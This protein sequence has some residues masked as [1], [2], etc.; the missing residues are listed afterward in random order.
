MSGFALTPQATMICPHGGTVVGIP[1]SVPTAGST[2]IFV[3]TDSFIIAGCPFTLP[4]PA[5]SPCVRVQWAV[6]DARS[7]INGI[8]TLSQTSVGMC[9][10]AAGVPQ[11]TVNVLATQT[12]V[13]TQ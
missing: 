11:G 8:A 3:Q 9:L 5:P 10:S 4:G 13:T 12:R 2:P 1:T 6:A 7:S